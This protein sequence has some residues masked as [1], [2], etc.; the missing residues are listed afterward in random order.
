M[1]VCPQS[2]NS[3]QLRD[4]ALKAFNRQKAIAEK[5]TKPV[6][7]MSL[8]HSPALM[9]EGAQVDTKPNTWHPELRQ[10]TSYQG[11]KNQT[12]WWSSS[13]ER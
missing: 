1:L 11:H 4:L 7:V 5:S 13:D 10:P 8:D 3:Q 12:L 9:L 6:T 2:I